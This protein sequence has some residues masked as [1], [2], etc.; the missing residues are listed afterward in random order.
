MTMGLSVP[1]NPNDPSKM[2]DISV[3]PSKNVTVSGK[4]PINGT[5][6]V[7]KIKETKTWKNDIYYFQELT[8]SW[9][10]EDKVDKKNLLDRN[11]TMVFMKNVTT[12]TY[13]ISE[14][15]GTIEVR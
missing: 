9:E 10:D 2:I 5:I 1:T 11:I 7:I 3:D 4:C 8:L 14:L 13:G 12:S 6:Q 15:K